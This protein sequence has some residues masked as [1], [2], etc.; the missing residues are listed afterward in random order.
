MFGEMVQTFREESKLDEIEKFYLANDLKNYR[1][2]VHAVKSTALS[3]GASELSAQAKALGL[4]RKRTMKTLLRKIMAILSKI[5]AE[6][7]SL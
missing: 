2:L 6:L 7:P 3:I 5:T 1:I 4:R